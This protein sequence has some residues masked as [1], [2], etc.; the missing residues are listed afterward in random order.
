M[1][2]SCRESYVSKL[3]TLLESVF[4]NAEFSGY[5][6]V[7]RLCK[8]DVGKR[9]AVFEC[10][11]SYYAYR[12]GNGYV[13]KS[14]NLIEYFTGNT[15]RSGGYNVF[16]AFSNREIRYFFARYVVSIKHAVKRI[17]SRIIDSACL[18]NINFL[19]KSARFKCGRKFYYLY[20]IGNIDYLE[21]RT[22]RES[23][24]AYRTNLFAVIRSRHVN[25]VKQR[26]IGAFYNL[27]SV[28]F[29]KRKHESVIRIVRVNAYVCY[30][31]PRLKSY[32]VYV[33]KRHAGAVSTGI[34]TYEHAVFGVARRRIETEFRSEY[35]FLFVA[36]SVSVY[37]Y[38][39]ERSRSPVC[40]KHGVLSFA[41]H[42][43]FVLAAV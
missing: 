7:L 19:Y 27:V 8:N 35:Y 3:N 14:G 31:I 4:C 22:I 41:V 10:R 42:Y 15:N 21:L 34:P 33:G 25:F 28:V 11:L 26:Y 5:F 13:S 12:C 32:A 37:I 18:I 23:V 38:H 20:R 40:V 36:I 17:V 39:S 24:C 43:F 6:T 1:R 2:K 30:R 9:R 16:A 29:L